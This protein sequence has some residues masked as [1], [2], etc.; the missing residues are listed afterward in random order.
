M[1]FDKVKLLSLQRKIDVFFKIINWPWSSWPGLGQVVRWGFFW[2]KR[3]KKEKRKHM[4]KKYKKRW[5]KQNCN[6][7]RKKKSGWEN[8][9]MSCDSF[10]QSPSEKE[11]LE[12][13]RQRERKRVLSESHSPKSLCVWVV[14]SGHSRAF[15][16][17]F[18]STSVYSEYT[19]SLYIC[20]NYRWENEHPQWFYL[21][22]WLNLYFNLN[23]Y[24]T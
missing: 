8:D 2:R 17:V 14:S 11:L 16:V 12:K 22:Y 20:H 23:T 21:S 15:Y 6:R 10:K 24:Y 7:Q 9:E 1:K 13:E 3:R 19:S 5:S 4:N 18:C